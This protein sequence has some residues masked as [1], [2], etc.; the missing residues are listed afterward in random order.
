MIEKYWGKT[1]EFKKLSE[2]QYHMSLKSTKNVCVVSSQNRKNRA[3]EDHHRIRKPLTLCEI[4]L[5]NGNLKERKSVDGEEEDGDT[6]EEDGAE[7]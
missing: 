3:G 5:R 7:D 4:I 6:E 2:T 1:K